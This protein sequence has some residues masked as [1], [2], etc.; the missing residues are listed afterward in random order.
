MVVVS[1]STYTLLHV[2]CDCMFFTTPGFPLQHECR[3]STLPAL[4]NYSDLH[5]FSGVSMLLL[6][7]DVLHPSCSLRISHY[8][9]KFHPTLQHLH[10]EKKMCT[11][12]STRSSQRSYKA[13]Y[14]SYQCNSHREAASGS[15]QLSTIKSN[16]ISTL[17]HGLVLQSSYKH[18]T[19]KVIS[20]PRAYRRNRCIYSTCQLAFPSPADLQKQRGNLTLIFTT[21]HQQPSAN[22]CECSF[23]GLI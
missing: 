16:I 17:F 2:H 19:W 14:S 5:I 18:N 23:L 15:M 7:P 6:L 4:L 11:C 3:K 13:I 8:H 22:S 10:G 12:F 21:P 9:N 1:L 20:L